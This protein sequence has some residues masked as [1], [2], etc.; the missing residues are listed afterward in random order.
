MQRASTQ[1][2]INHRAP[3][4]PNLPRHYDDTVKLETVE[5]KFKKTHDMQKAHRAPQPPISNNN[6]NIPYR[7]NQKEVKKNNH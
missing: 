4:K 1:L 2:S 5:V 3:L 6:K 7:G